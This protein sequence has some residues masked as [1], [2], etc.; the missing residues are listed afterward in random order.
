MRLAALT[1]A[2]LL[3]VPC[4]RAQDAPATPALTAA[5]VDAL[6]GDW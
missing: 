4:A 5:D 3:L 6:V 1:L 2:L